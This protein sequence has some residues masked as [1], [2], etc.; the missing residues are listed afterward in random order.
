MLMNVIHLGSGAGSRQWVEAVE[1]YPGARN[2][3]LVTGDSSPTVADSAFP[4]F[5][6]LGEALSSVSADV[7]VVSGHRA[8]NWAT[9]ALDAK[10]A[11]VMDEA[12]AVDGAAFRAF[13]VAARAKGSTVLWPRRYRYARCEKVLKRLIGSGWLGGIGHVSCIDEAVSPGEGGGQSWH[14]STRAFAHFHALRQLFGASP[15]KITARLGAEPGLQNSTEAFIEFEN[16]LH[17]H[18][19]GYSGAQRNAHQLW[20]EGAEGS[21]RTDGGAVWWRKRGWRFFMPLK[22]GL[23]QDPRDSAE[24]RATLDALATARTRAAG[25]PEDLSAVATVAAAIES[26]RRHAAV[27]LSELVG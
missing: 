22:I 7:A 4:H 25:S 19:S 26:H 11:V 1:H 12:G 5:Q 21:V 18:Y 20:I 9:Q 17:V 6:S 16:G 10:L 14:V 27:A 3:A 23:A 8:T 2:M 15:R 13:Q 24:A